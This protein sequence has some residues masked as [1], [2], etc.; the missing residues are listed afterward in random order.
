M[1]LN[2]PHGFSLCLYLLCCD[3]LHVGSDRSERDFL[4]RRFHCLMG[5][6]RGIVF[7][8][9]MY[10][11]SGHVPQEHHVPPWGWRTHVH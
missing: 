10:H 8:G 5:T 1:D 6:C 3:T 4:N 2:G 7:G 9:I 11:Q